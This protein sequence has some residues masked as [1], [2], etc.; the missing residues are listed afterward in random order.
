MSLKAKIVVGLVL[1]VA[2]SVAVWFLLQPKPDQILAKAKRQLLTSRSVSY[3][4]NFDLKGAVGPVLFGTPSTST[5]GSI[6]GTAKSS[7]DL[8]K[9]PYASTSTWGFDVSGVGGR[10][11]L[12]KGASLKKDGEH[13]FKLD[14]ST[15]TPISAIPAPGRWYRSSKSALAQTLPS[16]DPPV[17]PFTVQTAETLRQ[18]LIDAD[19]LKFV[20][21]LP[22]AKAA[23]GAKQYHFRVRLDADAMTAVLMSLGRDQAAATLAVAAWNDPV[24]EIW[25][26]KKDGLPRL[27]N[28]ETKISG[29]RGELD[30]ALTVGFGDY[31]KPVVFQIP[32]AAD[33]DQSATSASAAAPSLAPGATRSAS[34]TLPSFGFGFLPLPKLGK[35]LGAAQLQ[36]AVDKL[37]NNLG[38][39]P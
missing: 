13:Y 30:L 33:L 5:S 1:W 7:I 27:L 25:I 39:K 4:L 16:S 34:A 23:D 35:D 2:V 29:A 31:G 18:A 37:V 8:S 26:S 6:H 11:G 17:P 38:P 32:E 24:G 36:Q 15:M 20:S 19:W 10:D 14:E 22:D 12:W 28:F 9:Y 21:R 3:D